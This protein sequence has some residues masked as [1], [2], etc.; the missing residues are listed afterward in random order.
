MHN[1]SMARRSLLKGLGRGARLIARGN[2]GADLLPGDEGALKRLAGRVHL[3]H[4]ASG[5]AGT[6]AGAARQARQRG[7]VRQ[8]LKAGPEVLSVKKG[9]R[10]FP[11]TAANL[12]CLCSY[13]RATHLLAEMVAGLS[14]RVP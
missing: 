5:A 4:N 11:K 1:A 7:H 3:Q 14:R 10:C 8:H 13:T 6:A 12:S 9:K 2:I